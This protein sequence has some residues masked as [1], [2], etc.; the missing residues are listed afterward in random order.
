M[1]IPSRRL[2]RWFVAIV[3]LG[4]VGR[5]GAQPKSEEEWKQLAEKGSAG[6]KFLLATA[7]DSEGPLN[8]RW[9]ISVS[10]NDSEAAR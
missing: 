7:Y 5:L 4:T 1:A 10:K 8:S 3:V 6:A 2:P 9:G